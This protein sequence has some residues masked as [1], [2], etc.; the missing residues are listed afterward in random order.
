MSTKR[1]A[2][3]EQRLAEM[4]AAYEAVA[5]ERDQLQIRY[6]TIAGEL[7]ALK[8]RFFARSSEKQQHDDQPQ[9]FDEPGEIAGEREVEPNSETTVKSYT[10][11]SGAR[12][13]LSDALQREEIV[14]DISDEDKCCGC[15]HDLVRIGE[16]I[17]EKLIDA[18]SCLLAPR[19]PAVSVFAAHR[20]A[21][22]EIPANRVPADSHFGGHRANRETFHKNLVS[23]NMNLAHPEHPSSGEIK[24]L[25]EPRLTGTGAQGGSVF[26]RR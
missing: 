20:F 22:F 5:A 15:G 6:E 3:L 1:I 9:L 2:Q 25:F 10:R 7:E 18:T 14:I 24:I 23:N 11:S 16:K 4:N 19:R 17:S 12:K 13:P 21:F 26:E 8:R